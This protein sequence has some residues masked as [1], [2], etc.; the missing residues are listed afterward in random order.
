MTDTDH[1]VREATPVAFAEFLEE[2]APGKSSP[3]TKLATEDTEYRAGDWYVARPDLQLHCSHESCNGTR[4]FRCSTNYV[5]DLPFDEHKQFFIEYLC[6]N[7]Q[8]STKTFALG[9]IRNDGENGHCHK[10]GELPLYGPPT[11]AKLIKMVGPD[12]DA[13]L[14]GRRCENQGLGVGAFVYYRR[15]VENQKNRVLDEI[16]RVAKKL[17][18][19][20]GLVETLEAA[21]VETQFSKALASVKNA[22][23]ETLFV[24]G[25]N[26][27]ALLHSALSEGLHDKSDDECL[28]IASSVRVVLSDLAERLGS[29]LKDEAELNNAVA[30]LAQI[31]SKA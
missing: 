26:P 23:P 17:G 31:K 8:T 10:F 11:P 19:K 20:P 13:F 29:A 28:E 1:L 4:F 22:I 2:A 9:A 6:S 14:K 18:S 21:K 15:V 24:N 5:T 25:H 3:I 16:I 12:R 7:C 27:L 30:R